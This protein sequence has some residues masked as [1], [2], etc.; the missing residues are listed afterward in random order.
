LL[1]VLTAHRQETA[2]L[3]RYILA[4]LFGITLASSQFGCAP[5]VAGAAGAA[6]GAGAAEHHDRHDHDKD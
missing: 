4:G 6:V 3:K 5:L 1:D 2:V